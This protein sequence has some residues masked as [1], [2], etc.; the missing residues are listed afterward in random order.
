VDPRAGLDYMEKFKFLTLLELE[1]R[2]LG[3]PVRSESLYR[4]REILLDVYKVMAVPSN[5]STQ[6]V[7]RMTGC[8]VTE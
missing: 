1:L 3:R 7:M 6:I 5:G 8:T 4:L 2:P